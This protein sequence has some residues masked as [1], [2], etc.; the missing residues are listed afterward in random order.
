MWMSSYDVLKPTGSEEMIA[1]E[2]AAGPAAVFAIFDLPH[3]RA[4]G[5]QRHGSPYLAAHV[6]GRFGSACMQSILIG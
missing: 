2:E 1:C 6:L 4:P 3:L 5:E